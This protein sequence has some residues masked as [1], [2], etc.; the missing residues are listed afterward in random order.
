MV[1]PEGQ[2]VHLIHPTQLSEGWNPAKGKQCPIYPLGSLMVVSNRN[3]ISILKAKIQ[4]REIKF[5]D[6]ENQSLIIR[7][8]L[9]LKIFVV[10]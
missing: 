3:T 2:V 9:K 1:S 6:V 8:E 5:R 7:Q 10:V 4:S